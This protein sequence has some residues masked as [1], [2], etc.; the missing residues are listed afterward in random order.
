MALSKILSSRSSETLKETPFL[1]K[2]R[3]NL[4]AFSCLDVNNIRIAPAHHYCNLARSQRKDRRS[5]FGPNFYDV[6]SHDK[7]FKRPSLQLENVVS[8]HESQ[9]SIASHNYQG[10]HPHF[11]E[12]FQRHQEN[13][14]LKKLEKQKED[15]SF[16]DINQECSRSRVAF[17]AFDMKNALP[18]PSVTPKGVNKT[19]HKLMEKAIKAK[20]CKKILSS[21]SDPFLSSPVIPLN[22]V[23]RGDELLEMASDQQIADFINVQ[24]HS[25]KPAKRKIIKRILERASRDIEELR[26]KPEKAKRPQTFAGG[27]KAPS[28][29]TI[30]RNIKT[31]AGLIHD[32]DS[33]LKL[34]LFENQDELCS[35]W[36]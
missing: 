17:H 28:N 9:M 13:R 12:K 10:Y 36:M 19:I 2:T 22:L 11:Q 24:S 30:V 6:T 35:P 5:G 7:V 25:P 33:G 34:D 31:T 23:Q 4:N 26:S 20:R 29:V 27:K 3:Q 32:Y 8:D 14:F 16:G 18:I 1:K 15:C 21:H